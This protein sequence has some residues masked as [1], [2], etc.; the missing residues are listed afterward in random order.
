MQWSNNGY[1]PETQQDVYADVRTSYS[2]NP[3]TQDTQEN[4]EFS[5]FSIQ[6]KLGALSSVEEADITSSS[7]DLM[8]SSQTL[9]M[10]YQR[11]YAAAEKTRT[12]SKLNTKQKVMIAGYTIVVLALIIAVTLCAVSVSGS[13]GT[14]LAL[15]A[16]YAETTAAIDDLAAQL[17]EDRFEELAQRAAEL[18]YIDASSSNTM[19]YTEL[20]TRPAQNFQVNSNWF[21]SLCDWFSNV[22]GG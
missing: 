10:S 12:A 2:S 3:F 4:Q 15:N 22:F 6:Q 14:A 20:E 21:D 5:L 7:P 17:Q 11:E 18:G 8:P 1:Q 9:Q 19:T 13:F 16:N